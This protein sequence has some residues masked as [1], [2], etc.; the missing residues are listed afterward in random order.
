[1]VV[2]KLDRVLPK[3]EWEIVVVEPSLVHLYQP[4]LLFLPFG[5]YESADLV[6]PNQP[7]LPAGVSLIRAEVERVDTE[8]SQVVLVGQDPIGYDQ[9]VIATGTIPRPH[10]TPGL[11]GSQMGKTVHEFYTLEGAVALGRALSEWE[12]GRLVVHIVELPIKCPVA[13]LEFAFLADDHFRRRGM[14]D[15]V[16]ITYVTPLSGAFTK[17]IAAHLLGDLLEDRGIGLEPDFYVER[18]DNGALVSYD[19]RS[20]SFDL[21]V[22][23][24]LNMGADFVAKSNLGDEL[25]HVKV[26]PGTFLA[27]D[28]LNV[29]AIGDAAALPTS[30]AGSV[31]HFAV[32]VFVE[33]FLNH[34]AGRPMARRF[35][36]HTNCFVETGYG[37]ALLI[38]FNYTTE[39]LPG[40][41]PLPV[42]GPLR[43]LKET[44]INH[45]GKLA[46][47]PIY[48]HMLL[49]GRRLP[50]PTEMSMSGKGVTPEKPNL[51]KSET[52]EKV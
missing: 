45:L 30:K 52:E 28:L 13:P 1:M 9:L 4:G 42:F 12:G 14:R 23:V 15:K 7:L 47:K 26:D 49:P 8:A 46:F 19:E 25:N 10:M 18:V 41:Y 34:I 16:E 39:P 38:D 51:A 35:D 36:G 48:W 6:K 22:T 43:L 17:P 11:D 5:R 33:N 32:D 20:I 44:R 50:V 29:F 2:N 40:S 27:N 21:L 37:K 31:A 24:P 3:S